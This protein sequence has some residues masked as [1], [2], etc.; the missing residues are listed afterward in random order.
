[1]FGQKK[2]LQIQGITVFSLITKI[3]SYG[4]KSQIYFMAPYHEMRALKNTTHSVMQ[5]HTT[6]FFYLALSLL[7]LMQNFSTTAGRTE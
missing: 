7:G 1:M 2:C 4:F 6:E 5:C 3:F